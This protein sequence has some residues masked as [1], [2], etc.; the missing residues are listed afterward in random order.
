[1]K[2]Y[3]KLIL[4]HKWILVFLPIIIGFCVLSV[5]SN[6]YC[7]LYTG[8]FDTIHLY[9]IPNFH[10]IV[11][12]MSIWWTILFFSGVI[13][14]QGNELIFLCV[15]ANCVLGCQLFLEVLY[16]ISFSLYFFIMCDSYQLSV[17][18]FFLLAAESFFMNGLAFL[19]IQ[20]TRNISLALGSVAVYCIFLLKFDEM[21]ILGKI[22]IFP[23]PQDILQAPI[24]WLLIDIG[25]A[26]ACHVMGIICFQK[27]KVYF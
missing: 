8:D 26:I 1:M 10:L 2:A 3:L 25:I 12:M 16:V 17:T 9:I 7:N 5:S 4:R 11:S 15:K 18:L 13:S 21:D 23:N 20:L 6:Y 14:E 22:S 24:H 27:R 19:L